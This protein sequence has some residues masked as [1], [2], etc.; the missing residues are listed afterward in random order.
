MYEEI[1]RKIASSHQNQISFNESTHT[2]T[3]NGFILPSVTRIMRRLT[4]EKYNN[5]FAQA[6][7][8]NASNRG[9]AIHEAIE[10]FEKYGFLP[11]DDFEYKSYFTNYLVAK[12]L[13]K[14]EVIGSEIMLTNGVYCG[15]IDLI[16]V[17]DGKVG[18]VDIKATSAFFPDL[19]SVQLAGYSKLV[20][21]IGIVPE[22]HAG[23]HIKESGYKFKD[24]RPNEMMWKTLEEEETNGSVL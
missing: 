24:I 12:R 13:E 5:D 21:H 1:K 14:F 23:L 19:L 7:M 20:Q 3:V 8:N 4:E 16:V 22:F 6:R 17:K 9:S 18:I 11:T 10:N 15:T 2:Y